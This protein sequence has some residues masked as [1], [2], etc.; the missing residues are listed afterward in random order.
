[1]SFINAISCFEPGPQGTFLLDHPGEKHNAVWA[2]KNIQI[3][4]LGMRL[5][6][7]IYCFEPGPQKPK[8]ATKYV[9]TFYD[10]CCACY[11]AC[12]NVISDALVRAVIC[13]N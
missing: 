12:D 7:T 13:F 11:D 2:H 4:F 5:I 1:M 8:I 9:L 10:E 6:N 3:K